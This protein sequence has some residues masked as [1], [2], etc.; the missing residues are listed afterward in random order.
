MKSKGVYEMK[1]AVDKNKH[2]DII[3]ISNKERK[4]V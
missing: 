2:Y 3:T 4:E 1:K